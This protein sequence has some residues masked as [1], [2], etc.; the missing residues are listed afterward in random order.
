MPARRMVRCAICKSSVRE[1]RLSAH[2]SRVHGDVAG[3]HLP[4]RIAKEGESSSE[5]VFLSAACPC[6]GQNDNCFRCGGWGYIDS[7][8]QGRNQ[9]SE[10]VAGTTADKKKGKNPQ[11]P[12]IK[13]SAQTGRLKS[14]SKKCHICSAKI[15]DLETH[16]RVF[17]GG[18]NSGVRSSPVKKS[19]ISPSSGNADRKQ[20]RKKISSD[21]S[22][23][24]STRCIE[25]NLDGARDYYSNY[26][27]QGRFGSHPAHDDYGD[28]SDP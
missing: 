25:R 16:M 4:E 14:N 1:D 22:G 6:G 27:E 17:H 18:I 28:D 19:R 26:R 2:V 13:H 9:P 15:G 11:R 21:S 10:F 8:S 23:G 12:K 20:L 3:H 5:G 24:K 7:I